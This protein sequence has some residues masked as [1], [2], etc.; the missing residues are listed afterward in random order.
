M[1]PSEISALLQARGFIFKKSLGQ[2]FLLDPNLLRAVADAGDV[3]PGDLVIEVGTG[4]GTLTTVLADR[5]AEVVTVELDQRIAEISREVIGDRA[6]VRHVAGDAIKGEH[7]LHPEIEAALASA[8]ARGLTA[9]CVSNFP[10]NIAT[11]LFLHLLERSVVDRAFPLALI[12][13]TVQREVAERLT[14]TEISKAYGVPSVL[15]QALAG[16]RIDRRIGP[17]AF[18]PRPKIESAVVRLDPRPE[19]NLAIRDYG[20]FRALVRAV[21]QYRRKTVKNAVERG[22]CL[23]GAAVEKALAELGIEPRSRVEALSLTTLAHL[24]NALNGVP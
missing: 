15:T 7:G 6:N 13:G 8:A 12:A 24:A 3:G 14:A 23:D 19:A 10:Y 22:L 5:A 9:K 1:K 16:V 20:Q 17:A 2:N 11:P 4:A 18:F 21:F